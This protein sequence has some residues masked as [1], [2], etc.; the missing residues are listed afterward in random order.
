MKNIMRSLPKADTESLLSQISP[1][2]RLLLCCARTCISPETAEQ[3]K[4]LV[5][6]GID[7]VS[8]IRMAIPHGVLPLLYWGLD[9]TCP[10]SVPGATLGQF[11]RHFHINASRNNFLTG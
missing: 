10:E 6:D 2:A 3:I 11:K 4:R 9:R 1:E 5:R 8:L 7:W